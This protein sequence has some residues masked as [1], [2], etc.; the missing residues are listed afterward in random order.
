[1]IN[2]VNYRTWLINASSIW[3]TFRGIGLEMLDQGGQNV[4][5]DHYFCEST[6]S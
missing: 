5:P 3:K 6:L 1:M 2:Q 4:R